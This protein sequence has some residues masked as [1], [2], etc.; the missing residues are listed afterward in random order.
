MLSIIQVIIH[1]FNDN[2]IINFL[3]EFTNGLLIKN[4][5]AGVLAII[6][7]APLNLSK[8]ILLRIGVIYI[9]IL[10]LIFIRL[11]LCLIINTL[12]SS[13]DLTSNEK[14]K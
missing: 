9:D 2:A 4:D 6:D 13:H 1:G 7:S 5:A 14:P 11:H 12:L 8:Y 10:R 3:V